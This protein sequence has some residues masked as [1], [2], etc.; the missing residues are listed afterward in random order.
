MR[1]SILTLGISTLM[2]LTACNN[3]STD[4]KAV[5]LVDNGEKFSIE[6]KFVPNPPDTTKVL[7]ISTKGLFGKKPEP[8]TNQ[9]LPKSYTDR[10]FLKGLVNSTYDIFLVPGYIVRL[11]PKTGE[12]QRKTLTAVIKNNKMPVSAPIDPESGLVYSNRINKSANFNAAAV[13]G[14]ISVGDKQM[15]E[16]IIQDISSST[17]PDS[18]IDKTLIAS[19]VEKQIP[20]AERKNYFYVKSATLT[21]INNKLFKETS[22]EAKVNSTY[23]T[24]EGKVFNSNEKFSRNRI[25]SV[26]L[27]SLDNLINPIVP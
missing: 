22:F 8:F 13:I 11:D 24:A 25:V 9:E 26:E 21:L 27:I 6:Q 15:M 14:G 1:N 23:V 7:E 20:E 12:Y 17:V 4:T 16:F 2:L 18:L 19:I 5:K 10:T 3:N